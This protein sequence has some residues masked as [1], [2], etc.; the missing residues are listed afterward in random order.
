MDIG[1]I[2]VGRMGGPM[3]R[4]LL[5]AGHCLAVYDVDE[6]ACA[7]LA[8]QGAET[9]WTPSSIAADCP[10]I[11]TSLPGPKEVELVMRGA[12]G[13]LS[14]VRPDTLVLET[15][16]IGPALSRGLAR[17]FSERG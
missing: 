6:D 16:T 14:A 4:R 17:Q 2:G 5:G 15:S 13:L 3:A 9:R 8:A 11:I 10:N 12:D 1:F 7:R